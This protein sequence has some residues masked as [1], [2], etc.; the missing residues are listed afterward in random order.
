MIKELISLLAVY[1]TLFLFGMIVLRTGLFQLGGRSL[2]RWM[3]QMTDTPWKGFII[4]IIATAL[5]QSSS[6]I[7]VMIVGLVAAK[8]IQFRHSIGIILG[9][10]I[11]TTF[12]TELLTLDVSS[13]IIP[14]LVVGFVALLI[15]KTLPFSLGCFAFG[16][17]CIFIAMD[18]LK[19]LAFPLSSIPN[20]HSFFHLTNEHLFLGVS[21]GAIMTALIQSSTAT[22]AIAM[23]FMNDHILH[24]PAGIAIM[25]GA[26]IGTCITAY[27]ASLG[28]GK[29][30][31][32]VAFANIWVNV[33]GVLLFLPIIDLLSMVTDFLTP[34]PMTQLAHASVIF[35]TICSLI[36][37]PIANRFASLIQRMHKRG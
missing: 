6:V 5:L 9:A 37:L 32:L 23:G 31:R 33:I 8:I 26:N 25:L 29:S 28:S 10:N 14:L 7:I 4:G 16:L 35:N 12:T 22:T 36:L 1:I 18:G 19:S 24:L 3:Q 20:I 13:L 30:A 11:G 17:S 15:P 21:L 2:Q 27:L 34:D